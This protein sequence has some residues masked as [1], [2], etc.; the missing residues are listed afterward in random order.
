MPSSPRAAEGDTKALFVSR[1]RRLIQQRK[2]YSE[3]LNP[4][5]IRLLDRAIDATYQDC[6]DYGASSEAR[7][8]MAKR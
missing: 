7:T 3:D 1:L 4:L 6:I 2:D 5:G 8:L